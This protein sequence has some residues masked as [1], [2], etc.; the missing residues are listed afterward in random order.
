MVNS[1]K[2]VEEVGSKCVSSDCQR[3]QKLAVLN[4]QG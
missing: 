3:N 4:G 1:S 2:A